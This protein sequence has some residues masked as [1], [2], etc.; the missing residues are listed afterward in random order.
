[1]FSLGRNV[2]APNV[3]TGDVVDP[4]IVCSADEVP[5]LVMT[6]LGLTDN[7]RAKTN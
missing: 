7:R 5:K 4:V 1:M 6:N 3:M 2:K